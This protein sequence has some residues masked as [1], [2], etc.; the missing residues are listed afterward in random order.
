MAAGLRSERNMGS[1]SLLGPLG[2]CSGPSE[3]SLLLPPPA[4]AI[5]RA[6]GVFPGLAAVVT[7]T[8]ELLWMADLLLP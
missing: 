5:E 1:C 3:V 7:F 4:L 2:C 8:V 6:L